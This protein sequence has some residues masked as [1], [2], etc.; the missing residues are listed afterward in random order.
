MLKRRTLLL[1][2]GLPWFRG[3][4]CSRTPPS[5]SPKERFH[6]RQNRRVEEGRKMQ[7]KRRWLVVLQ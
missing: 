5:V 7:S 1:V 3:T 6:G 4:W 2:N